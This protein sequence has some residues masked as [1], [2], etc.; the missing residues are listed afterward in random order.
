MRHTRIKLPQALRLPCG[1]GHRLLWPA[2]RPAGVSPNPPSPTHQQNRDRKGVAHTR[3]LLAAILTLPLL[4]QQ[5]PTDFTSLA[6]SAVESQQSGNY[7]AAADQYQ[8]ALKLR[9]DDVATHVNLGVVLVKLGRFEEAIAQYTAAEKLLPGDQRIALNMALA[10]QKSGRMADA[11]ARFENLHAAEPQNQQVTLLLADGQL[12]LGDDA[13]V[14]ELLRPVEAADPNDLGVAYMLG[15]AL[16]REHRIE[17]GQ[18][19]LDRILRNGD[20]AEARF[21]LGTRMLEAGDAPAAVKQLASAI[22]SNARLPELQAFYGEALLETGD[23]ESAMRAFR[24]ELNTNAN[25]SR[26]NLGLSQ[27]LIARRQFLDAEP[28]VERAIRARPDSV[29]AKLSLAEC[30]NAH[31]QFANAQPYAETAVKQLPNSRETHRTLAAVYAGLGRETDAIEQRTMAQAIQQAADPGPKVNDPAPAFELSRVAPGK[32]LGLR[33]FRGK[34]PVVLV[35]GSYS[36]PNFRGSAEE[37]TSLNRRYGTRVPFLLVYIREAHAQGAGW[38]STRNTSE[39]IALTPANT[40]AEK[41]EHAAMCSRKLHL[42]FQAVVDGMDGAVEKAYNAWPSRLFVVARDGRVVYDT[43][44]TELDFD[45]PAL[46]AVLKRVSEPR[47]QEGLAQ[48]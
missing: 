48:R 9:P 7:A 31:G 39:K 5:P 21:L 2:N 16:L 8:A 37:L 41:E 32:K 26:A 45:P 36:C 34:T 22:Q 28:L 3:Y 33:D 24:N 43:R 11:V 19:L 35:F 38:Q 15:T 25:D 14:I 27:I 46:D 40:M 6:Q 42:P 4:A 13:R 30:L 23:P 10:Y 18:V 17:Q 12:Q 44:L 1:A 47:S 20:S 29:E